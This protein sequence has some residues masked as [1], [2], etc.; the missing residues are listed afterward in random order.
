[1]QHYSLISCWLTTDL[2]GKKKLESGFSSGAATLLIVG[3][4]VASV[5]STN[6]FL[7]ETGF[8]YE[9]Q[10][11]RGVAHGLDCLAHDSQ[12]LWLKRHRSF[13]QQLV[14][15]PNWFRTTL[16]GKINRQSGGQK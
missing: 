2:I 9:G 1:V 6:I 7:G 16:Y 8:V 13:L 14:I 4:L 15:N 12:V 3:T 10:A 11:G 5:L